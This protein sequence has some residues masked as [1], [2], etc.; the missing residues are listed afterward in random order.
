MRRILVID[1]E[2]PIRN[3]LTSMLGREAFVVETAEDG[4]A[5]VEAFRHR[6]PD[7]VITDILMPNKGGLVA[8]REIL[9]LDPAMK[10]VAMSGGGRTGKL[11]F[12]START[13]PGVQTL[14]KPFRQAE[15]MAAV[16]GALG[17][18]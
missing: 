1:D 9:D 14:Q 10:I 13:F 15:L 12:L 6:R 7:L 3:L 17:S 11:N 8:I 5:G 18:A 4:A 16:R 2:A